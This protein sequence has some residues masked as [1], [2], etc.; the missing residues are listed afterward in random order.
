MSVDMKRYRPKVGIALFA[1][2]G[3][4]LIARRIDAPE[5][6]VWQ[7][8]QGGMDPGENPHEAALRE[9]EEEIGVPPAKVTLLEEMDEWLTYD[10][11]PHLRERE[12]R[13]GDHWGQ[14]QK[15]FALRFLGSDADIRL[16]THTPEFSAW[17]WTDLAETPRLIVPFKRDVYETIARRFA[18]HAQK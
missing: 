6:H 10:F 17:R 8:P 4:V 15:W 14:R 18:R 13:R 16:D 12:G 9:L 3:Q 2:N 7:M 5:P 11:P 1:A